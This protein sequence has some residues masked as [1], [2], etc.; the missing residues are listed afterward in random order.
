MNLN[1]KKGTLSFVHISR[2]LI[3]ILLP[4]SV[5]LIAGR[6]NWW[7][8]WVYLIVTILAAVIS[9]QIALKNHPDLIQERA[10]FRENK[11]IPTWDRILVYLVVYLP[12]FTLFVAALDNRLGWSGKSSLAVNVIGILLI[13]AGSAFSTWA[14]AV[15]QYF[16]SIVRIQTDRG[17]HVIEAGPYSIIRHPG[18]F[19]GLLAMVGLPFLTGSMWAWI[20]CIAGMIS[21]L[22]RTY[23]EDR[24]LWKELPGY[25]D[26]S[27]RVKHRIIP[28]IW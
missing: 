19:G 13:V 21:I 15:N 14:F 6:W 8:I 3:V 5:F 26:Y 11:G 27:N 7:Q 9:R 24:F 12:L 4:L 1:Q 16:S 23:L 10:K 18:Y 28:G 17:H 25:E 2:F 20:P 22:L